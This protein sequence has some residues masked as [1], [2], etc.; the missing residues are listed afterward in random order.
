LR[1]HILRPYLLLVHR[2]VL[3]TIALL[4]AACS[5]GTKPEQTVP[6]PTDSDT[7]TPSHALTLDLFDATFPV[8]DDSPVQG[9][10][11]GATSTTAPATLTLDGAPTNF[12]LTLGLDGTFA[13]DLPA[14]GLEPTA[15]CPLD[16]A[17]CALEAT[18]T[19]AL[20]AQTASATADLILEATDAL[21]AYADTDADGHGDPAVTRLT[22]AEALDGYVLNADDCDD[23]R[24]DVYPDA[25]E[26]CD[27]VDNNCD[28]NIDE[29]FTFQPYF[30]D[31]DGDGAGDPGTTVTDCA[32]PAN[33]VA[34]TDDC[35]DS[36]PLNYL[37]N[38]EVCDDQDNDCDGFVDSD[39]DSNTEGDAYYV[40]LDGDTYIGLTSVLQCDQPTGTE[41][42][43]WSTT[44]PTQYVDAD[45]DDNPAT[46][47]AFNLEDADG[48]GFT[49]CP[50]S[51]GAL[52]DCNDQSEYQNPGLPE[53]VDPAD[54]D[55]NCD[56]AIACYLDGDNDGQGANGDG[57]N[58][59]NVQALVDG[60]ACD[61]PNNGFASVSGDCNDTQSFIYTGAVEQVGNGW[62]EDCSGAAACYA[63]TDFDDVGAGVL[64]NAIPV[65]DGGD[66]DGDGDGDADCAGT[67]GFSDLTGDCNDSDD[68][69]KPGAPELPADGINQNCDPGEL[70]AC[71]ADTDGDTF[72]DPGNIEVD[73]VYA[74][75]PGACALAA[76]YSDND[77]D[78][79]DTYGAGAT[80][81]PD[82]I[83]VVGDDV[84]QDCS[85]DF[86]CYVDADDDGF[87][88]DD[89][90][91]QAY[92]TPCSVAPGAADDMLDCDD[93]AGG[94]L[95]NPDATE[96]VGNN[97]DEDC[98]GDYLCFLDGDTDTYAG[99]N[100]ATAT[101]TDTCLSPGFG[102]VADDCDD[103][104][105][106][107]FPGNTNGFCSGADSDCDPD[108]VDEFVRRTTGT[109]AVYPGDTPAAQLTA[110]LAGAADSDVFELCD[111]EAFVGEFTIDDRVTLLGTD[112]FGAPAPARVQQTTG[113]DSVFTVTGG[114]V[115]TLQ[116]IDVTGDVGSAATF[117]GCLNVQSGD[118]FLGNVN[119]NECYADRG[120][121][122]YVGPGGTL[123]WTTGTCTASQ[124]TADNG[125]CIWNSGT[126]GLADTVLSGNTA[127]ANGGGFYVSGLAATVDWA[128]GSCELNLASAGGCFYAGTDSLVTL[129]DGSAGANDLIISGDI[130]PP[131][132]SYLGNDAAD[133]E[134]GNQAYTSG[135]V[136]ALSD[137]TIQPSDGPGTY[138][139]VVS[140]VGGFCW[141]GA[142]VTDITVNGTLGASA[143]VEG[144]DEYCNAL[145][146]SDTCPF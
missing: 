91:V 5:T 108:N 58:N 17:P 95:I 67:V 124:A 51:K 114:V 20:D 84:D 133:A 7:G 119:F 131:I 139:V 24:D 79:N 10:L 112:T 102:L 129:G 64:P 88:N 120:G 106:N 143:N 81:N 116:D 118:V 37:G 44:P 146:C 9:A 8:C 38:D 93:T 61:T 115:V 122:V 54:L 50:P 68:T 140:G 29:S 22:C 53:L 3:G 132:S 77:D 2:H 135:N 137:V 34:N 144:T 83:D 39:D 71:W 75:T 104:N 128:S 145:N 99:T 27:G 90:S 130:G 138:D 63:D 32:P 36:D 134:S 69:I 6:L 109:A 23:T 30:A 72:G 86:D 43:D 101:G 78:C 15:L 107:R 74:D 33:Y 31:S 13:I 76:N 111:N 94:F 92:A 11:S 136:K 113:G 57:T 12:D 98:D 47:A 60:D 125:G 117:G 80:I 65:T 82:A 45:C 25:T 89:G 85:F 40:D 100:T 49:S 103:G 110:A 42:V 126:V 96:L 56:N 16:V 18:L 19:V 55:E 1:L 121:A 59:V 46:G 48:D 66:E 141:G 62:D 127:T 97:V 41:G 87:G 105:I 14:L 73:V 28:T 35:D 26:L 123:D 21:T 142:L 70:D 4:L 52:T